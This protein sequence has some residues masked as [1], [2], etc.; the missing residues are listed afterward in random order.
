MIGLSFHYLLLQ[1]VYLL[2]ISQGDLH[3]LFYF[4]IFGACGKLQVFGLLQ[5]FY[6]AA[7][8][9]ED[10]SSHHIMQI[11]LSD[12]DT[13]CLLDHKGDKSDEVLVH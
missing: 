3:S 9:S 5:T 4:G 7:A 1:N 11:I 10:N 8:Y 13:I 6:Q 12:R 2:K